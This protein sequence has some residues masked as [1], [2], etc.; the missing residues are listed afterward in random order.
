MDFGFTKLE[1]SKL[2][3]E[4]VAHSSDN[5]KL[6]C[7]IEHVEYQFDL[8]GDFEPSQNDKYWLS[9]VVKKLAQILQ[10]FLHKS[11]GHS[12]LVIDSDHT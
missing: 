8:I 6:V 7:N 5:Y 3:Q 1:A 11:A 10:L 12:K 2:P 9:G 4:G